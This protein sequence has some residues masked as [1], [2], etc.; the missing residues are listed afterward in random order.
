ME[1]PPIWDFF[2]AEDFTLA[3]PRDPGERGME[4]MVQVRANGRMLDH[5]Q[6]TVGGSAMLE[7][8]VKLADILPIEG[9][10]EWSL[11][12]SCWPR[13]VA[14]RRNMAT[15]TWLDIRDQLAANDIKLIGA[16][17]E[18]LA[19]NELLEKLADVADRLTCSAVTRWGVTVG[20]DGKIWLQLQAI[21][22]PATSYASK[23]AWKG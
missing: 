21:P 7:T 14:I 4:M 16:L 5:F 13:D 20:D 15:S 19:S 2:P 1:F 18:E 12:F 10:P 22:S 8:T 9:L 11:R 23:P 3:A 17:N 6:I